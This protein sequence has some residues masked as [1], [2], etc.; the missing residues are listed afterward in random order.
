MNYFIHEEQLANSRSKKTG[1]TKARIDIDKIFKKI[2]FQQL[3]VK[4]LPRIGNPDNISIDLYN[5]LKV[6]KLWEKQTAILNNEDTVYFQ[7]PFEQHSIFLTSVLK[8]LN[9][10]NVR[11]VAIIHDIES[12]RVT[13]R[14]DISYI[15]SHIL[16][17]EEKSI[18][19]Y[20]T[21]LIVLNQSMKNYL[22][23]KGVIGPKLWVINIFDYFIP[24]YD[25]N[26]CKKPLFDK[27]KP[28]II[29]GTLRK[30]KASYIYDLPGNMNFNLYGV[31]YLDQNRLNIKYC[32]SYLPDELPLKLSGSFG[33]A[34][35][36]DSI[37]TCSGIYGKY[38]KINNPHK[39][40][41]YL[42]AGFP[43]IIWRKAAMADFILK[44]KCGIVIDSISDIE[45]IRFKIS[46]K[47]YK[48]LC[49]NANIVGQK[50]RQGWYLSNIVKMINLA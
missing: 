20:C 24:G 13:K 41:L 4:I 2:G 7:F 38:L 37:E 40:S 45:S 18:F 17:K 23:K 31:G 27:N 42:S 39:V 10:K 49:K 30:H 6:M 50:L 16:K 34:W 19:N 21:D 32:G 35:D 44:N 22:L 15:K 47:E 12:I 48:Q 25:K 43:V 9:S 3:T 11:I 26:Q 36:G 28:I 33:L 14:K 29:A 1:G 8:S 5:H 46:D